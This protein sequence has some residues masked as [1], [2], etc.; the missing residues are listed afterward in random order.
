MTN[1]LRSPKRI[2]N[3]LTLQKTVNKIPSKS[4]IF[5]NAKDSNAQLLVFDDGVDKIVKNPSIHPSIKNF[6][7][8]S[9]S[10]LV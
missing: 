6:I 10:V 5:D 7:F 4:Q 8:L 1:L 3:V 2:I 9:L